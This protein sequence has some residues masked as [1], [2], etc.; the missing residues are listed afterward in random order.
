MSGALQSKMTQCTSL[1]SRK[2]DYEEGAGWAAFNKEIDTQKLLYKSSYIRRMINI[3]PPPCDTEL[4]VMVCRRQMLPPQDESKTE[5]DHWVVKLINKGIP[6][7]DIET[8]H[9]ALNPDLNNGP[10]HSSFWSMAVYKAL[11]LGTQLAMP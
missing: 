3:I 5:L 9:V 10:V 7:K 6:E 4:P 8:V 11:E 2:L 1:S